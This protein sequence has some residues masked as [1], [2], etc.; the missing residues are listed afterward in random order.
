[1]VRSRAPPKREGR[2]RSR[3]PA[4]DA[5]ESRSSPLG[6]AYGSTASI[7]VWRPSTNVVGAQP[8]SYACARRPNCVAG[9]PDWWQLMQEA[10]VGPMRTSS[11]WL[12]HG[13]APASTVS[14][15]PFVA[16]TVDGAHVSAWHAPQLLSGCGYSTLTTLWICHLP[17]VLSG[18]VVVSQ[19][20]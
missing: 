14:A 16:S 3:A 2:G 9:S 4:P 11:I 5:P 10:A 12:P 6:L 13:A 17:V 8:W 20:P 18:P 1:M 15:T 7:R 19:L